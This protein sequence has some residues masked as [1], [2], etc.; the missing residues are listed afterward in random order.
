M[1]ESPKA[2]E[3]RLR[4]NARHKDEVRE[5]HRLYN[6][7]NRDR[8]NACKRRRYN[9]NKEKFLDEARKYKRMILRK[10]PLK[11]VYKSM[12]WRCS[13]NNSGN[14]NY[15]KKGITICKEWEDFQTF[16]NWALSHGWKKCLQIDRIDNSKGYSPDNC[17]FVTAKVNMNNR[18][19][20]S[21]ITIKGVVVCLSDLIEELHLN[22]SRQ[23][24]YTRIFRYKWSVEKALLT[25]NPRD[26]ESFE[27][28]EEIMKRI[29]AIVKKR[30]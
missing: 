12:K 28:E 23:T 25:P 21:R 3:R 14:T 15:K 7:K 16:E 30:I 20:T 17:R 11:S 5:Y 18:D 26:K 4:Y 27:G 24:I 9:S 10:H 1:K 2:R 13:P 29:D 6:I 22:L 19:Y 8:I